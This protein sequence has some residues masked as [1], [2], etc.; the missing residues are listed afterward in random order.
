AAVRNGHVG[1]GLIGMQER[2]ALYGGRLETGPTPDGGY[3]VHAVLPT[4]A[5]S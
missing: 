4:G 2:V 1:H 3:L 5:G